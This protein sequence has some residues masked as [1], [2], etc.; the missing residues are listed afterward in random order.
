VSKTLRK[1]LDEYFKGKDESRKLFDALHDLIETFD[2]V[3]MRVTKS[4]IA[5]YRR[6]AFAWAWMPGKYLHGKVA[7]LVLTLSLPSRDPSARWKEIVEPCPG[8]FTHHLELYATGDID[9]EV[10]EWVSIAWTE[11]A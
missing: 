4:Q 10:R 5:F 8:R 11:A 9:D 7:P 3:E 2:G 1:I 6:R